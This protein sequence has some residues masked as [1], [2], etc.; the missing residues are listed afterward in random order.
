[1]AG[2][3]QLGRDILSRLI[4]GTR[5]AMIVAFASTGGTLLVG[6]LLGLVAGYGPRQLDTLFMLLCDSLMSIPMICLLWR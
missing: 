2:Q 1:M 5:V 3:R 6:S 4:Y